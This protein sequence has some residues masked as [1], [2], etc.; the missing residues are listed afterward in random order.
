MSAQFLLRLW[1]LEELKPLP[2]LLGKCQGSVLSGTLWNRWVCL[3]IHDFPKISL[4]ELQF[5]SGLFH[6][7]PKFP[8]H[9]YN[10]IV[11]IVDRSV[12]HVGIGLFPNEY[13]WKVDCCFRGHRKVL[14]TSQMKQ[15]IGAIYVLNKVR[16]RTALHSYRTNL[17][18]P[19]ARP[20]WAENPD[21]TWGDFHILLR[22]HSAAMNSFA[23]SSRGFD[24]LRPNLR[25]RGP[26]ICE[27]CHTPIWELVGHSAA[28]RITKKACILREKSLGQ[29]S[30]ASQEVCNWCASLSHQQ[31]ISLLQLGCKE[32]YGLCR[33]AIPCQ[34]DSHRHMICTVYH[35]I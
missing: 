28:Q 29:L 23:E 10:F 13:V 4:G 35:C 11:E 32:S 26:E 22:S 6:L 1:T 7:I 25:N 30:F 5:L 12:K 3:K 19:Q 8:T 16:C 9:S 33:S 24:C 15:I 21:G 34:F 27:I 20:S 2:N 18:W 31:L 17:T 14:S